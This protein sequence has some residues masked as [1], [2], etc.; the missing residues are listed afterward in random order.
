MGNKVV[1]DVSTD[2]LKRKVY[3]IFNSLTSRTEVY[4]YFGL[5]DNS[6]GV[7]HVREIAS[8]IGFDL[9]VYDER[10][11]RPIRFCKECGKEITSKYAKDFCCGSCSSRYN[12]RQRDKEMYIKIAEKLRARYPNSKSRRS[13]TKNTL[14]NNPKPKSPKK[15][16]Y[17]NV[18]VCCGKYFESCKK[19]SKFC[20]L[21]CVGDYKG[22]TTVEMWLKNEFKLNGNNK[23]PQSIK[24]YLLEKNNYKC[25]MC[26]FEGY[27]RKTG[28]SILQFHHID[29]N[30][31]NNTKE[32]IQVLCP[33]CHAMTENFMALNKGKSARDKRYKK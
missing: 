4:K 28:N 31:N 13:K 9:S 2:E 25:E 20:S 17:T 21:K 1:I 33:N 27:N 12:N 15:K 6:Y 24:T 30:S 3:E 7:R 32:N 16:R 26:G 14:E 29:G 19:D 8:K 10:R 18:C 22:K 11:K 5:N 23:L